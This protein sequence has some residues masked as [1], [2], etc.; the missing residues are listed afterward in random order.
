MNELHKQII[1]AC[2]KNNMRV[3]AVARELYM[4]RNTVMYH[5]KQIKKESGFDP[6]NFFDLRMLV[7]EVTR[8]KSA[9]ITTTSKCSFGN[10]IVKPDGVNEL[11]PC[12]YQIVEKYSNVTIEILR[13]KKCGHMEVLWHRQ[14]DTED[15]LDLGEDE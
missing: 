7:D 2:A 5:L 8:K 13:C 15:I 12:D 11:D 9:D 6:Q 10:V 3:G 4:H 14:D 1:L